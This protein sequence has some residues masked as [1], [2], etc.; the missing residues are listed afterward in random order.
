MPPCALCPGGAQAG[1]AAD[2]RCS[3]LRGGGTVHKLN[4]GLVIS[5]SRYDPLQAD[6]GNSMAAAS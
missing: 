2:R 6:T 1:K 3:P 5:P 4:G